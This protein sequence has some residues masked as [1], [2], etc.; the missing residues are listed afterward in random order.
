MLI[1]NLFK[2]GFGSGLFR[3]FQGC[4][5]FNQALVI[6]SLD[7][8]FD[9]FPLLRGRPLPSMMDAMTDQVRMLGAAP[10]SKSSHS[11][12]D[13]SFSDGEGGYTFRASLLGKHCSVATLPIDFME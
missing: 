10:N 5:G 11:P 2:L 13:G 6:F 3:S 12:T 7:F 4:L 9:W 8:G 1:Q